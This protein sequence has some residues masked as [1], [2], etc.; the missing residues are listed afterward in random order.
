MANLLFAFYW[1]YGGLR[2]GEVKSFATMRGFAFHNVDPAG[3]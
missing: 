3:R 1:G 2:R